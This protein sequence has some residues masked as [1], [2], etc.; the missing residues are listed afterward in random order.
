MLLIQLHRLNH[1]A[2]MQLPI[3]GLSFLRNLIF[4]HT[5]FL[6]HSA[7]FEHRHHYEAFS[8]LCRPKNHTINVQHGEKRWYIGDGISS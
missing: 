5:W 7:N 6:L 1:L 8:F 3:F 2:N 4:L